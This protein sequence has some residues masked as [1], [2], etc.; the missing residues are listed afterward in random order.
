MIS[1]KLLWWSRS[2]TI[3]S[4][5]VRPLAIAY[6]EFAEYDQPM[7][8]QYFWRRLRSCFFE[9]VLMWLNCF[10]SPI[11]TARLAR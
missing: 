2:W 4:G 3:W 9:S 11:I 8:T 1:P 10:G 7:L 5:L 6:R